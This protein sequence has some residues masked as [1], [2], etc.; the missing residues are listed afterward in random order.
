MSLNACSG[1][2]RVTFNLQRQG[3]SVNQ[4]MAADDSPSP[5]SQR[6]KSHCPMGFCCDNLAIQ[7][8]RCH[9]LSILIVYRGRL[10]LYNI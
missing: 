9:S 8:N 1:S 7:P 3:V 4:F 6:I 10:Q 5:G 2:V